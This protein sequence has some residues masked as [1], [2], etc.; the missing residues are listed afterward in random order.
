MTVIADTVVVARRTEVKAQPPI[1]LLVLGAAVVGSL[2][3]MLIAKLTATAVTPALLP[4][5]EPEIRATQLPG[6]EARKLEPEAPAVIEDFAPPK[7]TEPKPRP[8]IDRSASEKTERPVAER[9]LDQLV[10]RINQLARL[11]KRARPQL[12]PKIDELINASLFEAAAGDTPPVRARLE[13]IAT[14]LERL[15]AP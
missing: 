10:T 5:P 3:V 9:S 12:A 4:E 11:A 2:A 7:R 6:V 1:I 13:E 8:A 14:E 15:A